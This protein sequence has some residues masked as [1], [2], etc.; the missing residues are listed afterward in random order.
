MHNN[1]QERS[2]S[3]TAGFAAGLKTMLLAAGVSI[4]L[5]NPVSSQASLP[6]DPFYKTSNRFANNY[7]TCFAFVQENEKNF[8]SPYGPKYWDDFLVCWEST[9]VADDFRKLEVH[10][11]QIALEIERTRN[12]ADNR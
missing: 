9:H 1:V 12:V 10:I 6:I 7:N 5:I 8:I 11:R 2:H 3:L 4:F